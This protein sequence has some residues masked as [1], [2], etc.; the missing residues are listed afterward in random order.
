MCDAIGGQEAEQATDC[1]YREQQS[2]SPPAKDK[3]QA[4]DQQLTQQLAARAPIARRTAISFRRA[5]AR[6]ISRFATLKQAISSTSPT[7]HINTI[8]A[9]ESFAASANSRWPPAPHEPWRFRNRS[10]LNARYSAC[11]R[12]SVRVRRIGWKSG[13]RDARADSTV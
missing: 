11:P 6:A 12:A 7:M 10:R 9:V 4:F 5:T 1:P 2:K 13:C 8:K 3:E